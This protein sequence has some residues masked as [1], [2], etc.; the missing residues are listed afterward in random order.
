MMDLFAV[1]LRV[2]RA[3]SSLHKTS[4]SIVV[5]G[6]IAINIGAAYRSDV[7]NVQKG[8]SAQYPPATPRTI[9]S[10]EDKYFHAL[11]EPVNTWMYVFRLNAYDISPGFLSLTTIFLIYSL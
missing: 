9:L 8:E 6:D 1:S 3:L 2:S 10:T 11:T 5:S 4:W 7:V